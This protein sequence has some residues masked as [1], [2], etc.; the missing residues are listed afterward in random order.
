VKLG[1]T[2]C[3]DCAPVIT[4]ANTGER[5]PADSPG[6]RAVSAIWEAATEE[7]RAA[8]HRV[9]CD[10]SEDP[11]DRSIVRGLWHRMAEALASTGT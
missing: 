2:I 5:L 11:E 4:D 1:V 10:R 3:H 9:T 7:E 8:M 6:M